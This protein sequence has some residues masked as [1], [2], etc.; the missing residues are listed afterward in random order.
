MRQGRAENRRASAKRL[1]PAVPDEWYFINGGTLMAYSDVSL[2]A[3]LRIE[4]KDWPRPSA[5]EVA[6]VAASLPGG[7][8]KDK[9]QRAVRLIWE[10]ADALRAAHEHAKELQQYFAR[11]G[12]KEK[13]LADLLG[14]DPESLKYPL[15]YADFLK[16]LN[17]GPIKLGR[18]RGV[19]GRELWREFL[20]L[21]FLAKRVS[22]DGQSV[23]RVPVSNAAVIEWEERHERDALKHSLSAMFY[24]RRFFFWRSAL[25]KANKLNPAFRQNIGRGKKS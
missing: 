22:N 4:E 3:I 15:P 10:C 23:E 13:E 2:S 8:E 7:D 17:L 20:R 12:E 25:V 9:A 19:E 6:R 1:K 18:R 21:E 5:V 14:F 16:L 11:A 24:A